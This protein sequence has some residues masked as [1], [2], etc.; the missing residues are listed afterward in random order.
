MKTVSLR[1]GPITPNASITGPNDVTQ[2]LRRG[3]NVGGAVLADGWFSGYVGYG[4]KRDHYGK[5]LRL[6]AQLQIVY[7]DGASQTIASGP[8]WKASEGPIRYA[9][10]LMGESFDARLLTIGTNLALTTASGRQ[11]S[12]GRKRCC[13]SRRIRDRG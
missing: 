5:N 2:S 6:R 1:V 10:F 9:D 8:D 11:S 12:P 13:C 4:H 7:A 3:A